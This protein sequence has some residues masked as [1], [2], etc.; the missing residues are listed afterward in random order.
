MLAWFRVDDQFGSHPKVMMIPRAERAACLGAWLLA[1]VWAAQHLTDGRVPDYM[2]DELGVN[3]SQRDR[4]GAVG[5]WVEDGHGIAFKDWEDHQPMRVDVLAA[6]EKERRRKEAYRLRRAG[7]VETT[8]ESPDGTD[9]GQDGGHQR[10]S[11]HPDPA[12][13]GPTRPT[14][15]ED[16][17]SSVVG[18]L[19]ARTCGKHDGWEHDERC[20]ACGRDRRAHEAYVAEQ[21]KTAAAERREAQRNPTCPHGFPRHE[22]CDRCGPAWPGRGRHDG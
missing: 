2:L 9:A 21:A 14:T 12:R 1:G 3:V 11:G 18:A 15:S 20:G 6:R 8:G 10:V 22:A 13:P 7:I 4:L 5:L 17:S 19:H 16:K